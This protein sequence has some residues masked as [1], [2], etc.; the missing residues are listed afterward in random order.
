MSAPA[1]LVRVAVV[2]VGHMGRHHAR[3]YHELPGCALAAVIDRDL[4]RAREIAA[5]LGAPAFASVDELPAGVQAASVA[6]PTT[7]HVPVAEALIARGIAVL[8]EKPLAPSVADAERLCAAARRGGVILAVGH[9]ERFN[10]AVRAMQRLEIEP[11]FIET[12]RISPFTF[13]SA[14]VSVVHDMMIHDIDILLH[15]VARGA[16]GRRPEVT[17]VHAVGVAVLGRHEDVVNARVAFDNGAVANLTASRLALKTERKLRIF[18][19]QAYLSVDYHR[20]T[21]IAIVKDKNLDILELAAKGGFEDLSQMKGVDFGKL[22]KVEP[23][24]VDDVEPLRAELESFIGCVRGGGAPAVSGDDGVAA[25]R[26]ADQI[27]ESC[28]AHRWDASSA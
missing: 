21:G 17:A 3:I 10:P 28:R 7:A 15:L 5:P 11:K 4:A 18:S 6:V 20:K 22:V 13:R 27:V 1:A 19:Q 26:L 9:T 25:M 12:D 16:G 8:V 14:D 23:L 24:L 2:G